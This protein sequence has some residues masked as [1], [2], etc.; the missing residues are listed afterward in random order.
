MRQPPVEEQTWRTLITAARSTAVPNIGNLICASSSLI[1]LCPARFPGRSSAA[2][3]CTLLSL[4]DSPYSSKVPGTVD[5]LDRT[6]N[7][8]LPSACRSQNLV[9]WAGP[10]SL[11]R[12]A[13]SVRE[14]RSTSQH[15]RVSRSLPFSDVRRGRAFHT[16]RR[17][18]SEG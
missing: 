18:A 16:Q 2:G 17:E 14:F 11:R 4:L 13:L 3:Q 12:L 5:K 7:F 9:L 8:G 6:R 10:S 15:W 1:K